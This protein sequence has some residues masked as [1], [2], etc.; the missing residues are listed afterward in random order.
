MN[1]THKTDNE[2][3]NDETVFIID[4]EEEMVVLL[5]DSVLHKA[6]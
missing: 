6:A 2:S 3:E 4:D 1:T 5:E